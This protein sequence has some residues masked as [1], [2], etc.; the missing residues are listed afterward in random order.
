MKAAIMVAGNAWL[1]AEAVGGQLGVDEVLAEVVR[2]D[3]DAT[4]AELQAR[5]AGIRSTLAAVRLRAVPALRR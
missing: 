4:V 2:Q 1:A 5:G 3:K